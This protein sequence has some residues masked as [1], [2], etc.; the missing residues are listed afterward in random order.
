MK[1]FL[2]FVIFVIALSF[3]NSLH[4]QL[5]L[6]SPSKEKPKY[7]MVIPI[8]IIN[9]S[10]IYYN[11]KNISLKNLKKELIELFKKYN[12]KAH[13]KVI[14]SIDGSVKVALIIDVQSFLAKNAHVYI[15]LKL[16]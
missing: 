12:K 3:G 7:D 16:I 9:T 4:A 8:K 1:R 13:Y 5:A 10:E 6:I 2:A 14:L 11:D 15:E